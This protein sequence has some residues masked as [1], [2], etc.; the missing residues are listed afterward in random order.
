MWLQ[1]KP[2]CYTSPD[3]EKTR[4]SVRIS[5]LLRF[6]NGCIF[7]YHP[8][9][10]TQWLRTQDVIIA[11]GNWNPRLYSGLCCFAIFF[12][13]R[14]QFRQRET[15]W[16][17]ICWRRKWLRTSCVWTIFRARVKTMEKKVVALGGA[18]DDS[19]SEGCSRMHG[20][21]AEQTHTS[22]GQKNG[23]TTLVNIPLSLVHKC[24]PVHQRHISNGATDTFLQ[25]YL[26]NTP[27]RPSFLD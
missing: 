11:P 20:T 14:N 16:I 22:N 25:T 10:V 12:S 17:K 26:G 23:S 21:T 24:A 6:L 5:P 1:L 2:R 9:H 19:A 27:A 4:S 3:T 15:L 8:C 7:P 18:S 13:S